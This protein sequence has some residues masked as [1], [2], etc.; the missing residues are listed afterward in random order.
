MG[1][2]APSGPPAAGRRWEGGT[3]GAGAASSP[4]P[5]P[6]PPPVEPQPPQ[7]RVLQSLYCANTLL[8]SSDLTRNQPVQTRTH[9]PTPGPSASAGDAAPGLHHARRF[10][11]LPTPH[12][13]G[14]GAASRAGPGEAPRAAATRTPGHGGRGAERVPSCGR[15]ARRR[16]HTR[17]PSVRSR[18]PSAQS[19]GSAL[20]TLT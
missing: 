3:G 4:R 19:A 8:G 14:E 6:A 13:W 20:L 17:R 11:S 9:S 5:G 15:G 7:P 16:A 12:R 1:L 10:P 2:A 18:G